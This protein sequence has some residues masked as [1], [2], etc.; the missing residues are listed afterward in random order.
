[1]EQD[2]LLEEGEVM[3]EDV[4][5]HWIVY[6]EDILLHTFGCI[7]FIG[8][9][10][11]LS[12]KG[13]FPFLGADDKAYIAMILV[14]FVIVFWNSFFYFW[15]KNYF[16]VWYVTDRHIIAVNQK[17]MFER[18]QAFM[19]LVKLQDV[20]FE[21]NGFLA[22]FLGYGKLKVQ[23]A[24]SDQEFVI[25]DVKDV[26]AVAHRIMGLRDKKTKG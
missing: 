5:K 19:E 24:G 3:I 14:F 11:F 26:E 9:A 15:T 13:V 25:E 12:L 4:R 2:Q 8:V 7:V 23:T 22:T 10:I 21:K 6:L 16:D 1:M 18:E 17:D 20:L